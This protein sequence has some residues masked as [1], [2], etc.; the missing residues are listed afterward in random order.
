[1]KKIVLF[2]MSVLSV[3]ASWSFGADRKVVAVTSIKDEACVLI[4]A[5]SLQPE[6]EIDFFRQECA[7]LAGYQVIFAGGDIRSYISL[8][9]GSA[10]EVTFRVSTGQFPNVSGDTIEWRATVKDNDKAVYE[11]I[12]FKVEGGD[13]ESEGASK[14]IKTWVA[15]KLDGAD[16]CVVGSVLDDG[17]DA[18][19]EAIR[20]IADAAP[21]S[22]CVAD[23]E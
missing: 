8:K 14:V 9:Y 21:N 12:V 11:S 15:V 20:K 18:S 17:S 22:K 10:E 23:N 1:M 16:S 5:D 7:G 3:T 6:P 4:N 2:A 13:P 19:L